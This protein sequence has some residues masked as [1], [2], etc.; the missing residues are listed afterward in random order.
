[1]ILMNKLYGTEITESFST[2]KSRLI[3]LDYDGTLVD[4]TPLPETNSPGKLICNILKKLFSDP[5]SDLC[6]ITGRRSED[7]EKIIGTLPIKIIAEHGA[8]IRE[9]G[10]WEV[11]ISND[12]GW[13]NF[14]LP[15]LESITS[16]CP[17]S[18]VEEKNFSLAWHYRNAEDRLGYESSRKLLGILEK[19]ARTYNL[20]FLDGNKVVEIM[21]SVVGK[22]LTV[23]WLTELKYYDFIL[24]IGDDVTDEEMFDYFLQDKSAYTIKVGSGKSSARFK[25]AGIND[26]IILLN[27][28]SECV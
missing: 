28:L 11:R 23:K 12:N 19:E 8:M 7:I 10:V 18:F 25:L 5:A 1:M 26:V 27:Q 3:L 14:V 2:A 20:K 9:K 4:H 22:G 17:N 24:C 15:L 21:S 13:K 6:I 16:V